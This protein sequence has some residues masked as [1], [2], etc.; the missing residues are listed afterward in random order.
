MGQRRRPPTPLL[1]RLPQL[2]LVPVVVVDPGEA[3]VALV[4]PFGV[5]PDA[6]FRQPLQ[7][8]VEIVHDVVHHERRLARLEVLRVAR[9]YAPD[10]HLLA[11]RVV[12]FPPRQDH[13]VPAVRETEM[14]RVPVLHLL[15][16]R[17]LEEDP[18]DTED[19][20]LLAHGCVPFT[21]FAAGR[22]M[23]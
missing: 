4:L 22:R 8:R 16:I 17:G 5:D 3:A 13:A 7:Q 20:A 11:V 1:D 9:E 10:R 2:D 18:A 15:L 23:P 6:V 14:L 21:W 12:L 19:S